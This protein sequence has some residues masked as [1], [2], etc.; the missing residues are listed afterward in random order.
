MEIYDIAG[1]LVR[2]VDSNDIIQNDGVYT[3]QWN[4]KNDGGRPVGN[5][6]YLY[7][8]KMSAGK[9]SKE[10]FGKLIVVR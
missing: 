9:R 2:K 3:Y 7:R 8:V 5:G 1:E 10:V 4:G 6:V